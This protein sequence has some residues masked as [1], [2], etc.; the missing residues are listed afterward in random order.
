M[1]KDFNFNYSITSNNSKGTANQ[2]KIVSG[3]D[4]DDELFKLKEQVIKL[5]TDKKYLSNEVLRLQKEIESKDKIFKDINSHSPERYATK[6]AGDY[7]KSLERSKENLLIGN[8]KKQYKELQAYCKHKEEE[9]DRLKKNM[10]ASKLSELIDENKVFQNELTKLR[11]LTYDLASKK[12]SIEKQFKEEVDSSKGLKYKILVEEDKNRKL[13]QELA[14]KES[15]ICDLE[16]KIS[17]LMSNQ[18]PNRALVDLAHD[19]QKYKELNDQKDME[20]E[21]LKGDYLNLIAELERIEQK[22]LQ[23]GLDNPYDELGTCNRE[24]TYGEKLRSLENNDVVNQC[25]EN[26]KLD[27]IFSESRAEELSIEKIEEISFLLEKMLKVRDID[28]S[29]IDTSLFNE[30]LFNSSNFAEQLSRDLANLL[31]L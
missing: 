11:E 9:S 29:Q 31:Q 17:E 4:K 6:M 18:G 23:N 2:G 26:I 13:Q 27:L 7:S 22:Q 5:N 14:S 8:L 1:N 16:S 15:S 24:I 10:R 21:N 30:E 28:I 25:T 19:C 12:V 3:T 20:I